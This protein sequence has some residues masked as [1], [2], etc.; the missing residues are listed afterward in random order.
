M[1]LEMCVTGNDCYGSGTRAILYPFCQV[2][3][4]MPTTKRVPKLLSCNRVNYLNFERS[5]TSALKLGKLVWP[6]GWVAVPSYTAQPLIVLCTLLREGHLENVEQASFSLLHLPDQYKTEFN[7][8]LKGEFWQLLHLHCLT[9]MCRRGGAWGFHIQVINRALQYLCCEEEW[10]WGTIYIQM[11]KM[12]VHLF[13]NS[14]LIPTK[15]DNFS[16]F[17]V[18]KSWEHYK[19]RSLGI[20]D[21]KQSLLE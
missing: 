19:Y 13:T 11:K 5:Y 7:E 2:C 12:A 3:E 14:Q 6:R 16:W 20:L 8:N 17:Q 18:Q 15:L 10:L 1:N 9:E 4:A 21:G